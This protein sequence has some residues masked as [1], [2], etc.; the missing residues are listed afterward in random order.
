MNPDRQEV[1]EFSVESKP[2]RIDRA[3]TQWQSI[4]T[5]SEIEKAFDLSAG[6]LKGLS[7]AKDSQAQK[8]VAVNL[9]TTNE[10]CNVSYSRFAQALGSDV[11][12]SSDFSIKTQGSQQFQLTG[13]GRGDGVGVC[14]YTADKMAEEGQRAPEILRAFFPGSNVEKLD[15]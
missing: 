11:V 3:R 2:A 15:L 14:L 6:S 12:K 10:N 5:Q 8:V 13:F 1:G 4:I 7:L 9:E